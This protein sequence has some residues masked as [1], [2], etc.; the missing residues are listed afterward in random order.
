MSQKYANIYVYIFFYLFYF[1]LVDI[2]HNLMLVDCVKNFLFSSKILISL[3][4]VKNQ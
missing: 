2:S 3:Q 1:V 4:P